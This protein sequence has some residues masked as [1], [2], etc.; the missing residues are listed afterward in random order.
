MSRTLIWHRLKFLPA[1]GGMG[2]TFSQ[3]TAGNCVRL[4]V[5]GM[6]TV[7]LHA[8]DQQPPCADEPLARKRYTGPFR[9]SQENYACHLTPYRHRHP[10]P[11][12]RRAG[13]SHLALQHERAF[14]MGGAAP[15]ASATPAPAAAALPPVYQLKRTQMFV[16]VLT[17]Q[18][19]LTSSSLYSRL[20]HTARFKVMLVIVIQL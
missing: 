4:L 10:P 7:T 2:C 1:I 8:A 17:D 11:P 20:N 16:V 14:N 15:R 19:Q 6:R 12:P 18:Q 5:G 13:R 9:P 3:R